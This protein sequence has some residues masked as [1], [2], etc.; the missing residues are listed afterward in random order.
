VKCNVAG[1]L[2]DA[3]DYD[4][5]TATVLAAASARRP[6]ALTALAVHGVVEAARDPVLRWRVNRLDVVAPDGQPVRWAMNALHRAALRDRVYGPTL[7]RRVVQRAADEGLGVYLY[8]GTEA[9]IRDLR[10]RLPAIV[11]ASASRFA[12]VDDATLDE[13]A[14][15]IRS[16][17]AALV[18]VGLGCPRQEMFVSVMRDR[19]G[20][21]LLAVGAAFDYL[22]GRRRE[23][24]RAVQRAGLQ[25]AWRLVAEP[26]RLWRRY[27]LLNPLYVAMIAAQA[28]RVWHPTTAGREP[29]RGALVPA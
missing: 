9:T 11:G 19:V 24:P 22:A 15:S 28:M 8:G 3:V 26:R 27:L 7:A 2:V 6:L 10:T 25:W 18:L 16:S 13:I 5:A 20:V 4:M 23:P 29:E 14:G 12:E 1:V 21:P 17:G